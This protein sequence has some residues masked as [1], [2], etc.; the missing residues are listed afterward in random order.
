MH[1]RLVCSANEALGDDRAQRLAALK[2]PHPFLRGYVHW[3]KLVR[4]LRKHWACSASRSDVGLSPPPAPL[5][6]AGRR[7]TGLDKGFV[8]HHAQ[9]EL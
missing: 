9:V 2:V 8:R 6:L 7:V 3:L 1:K 4:D 5:P